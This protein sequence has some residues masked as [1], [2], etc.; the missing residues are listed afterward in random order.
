MGLEGFIAHDEENFVQ[1][2]VNLACELETL[3]DLL[4]EL[5]ERFQQSALGQ[6]ELIATVLKRALHVMWHR[7]SDRLPAESFDVW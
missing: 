2:G 3:A 5:R 1:K 6:P 4:A 7:C